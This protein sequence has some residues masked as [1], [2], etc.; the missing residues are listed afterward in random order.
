MARQP[1]G[2]TGEVGKFFDHQTCCNC[3]RRA[4]LTHIPLVNFVC[5][6]LLLALTYITLGVGVQLSISGT[7]WFETGNLL[8]VGCTLL[9]INQIM[10]Y[11]CQIRQRM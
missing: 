11:L 2:H 3:P 10:A 1:E 8:P 4:W 7:Y 5:T 9:V 6:V